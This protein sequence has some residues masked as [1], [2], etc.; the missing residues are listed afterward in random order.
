MEL[1]LLI[2]ALAAIIAFVYFFFY[3]VKQIIVKAVPAAIVSMLLN[4]VALIFAFII[5]GEE[6]I[7]TSN[8]VTIS[9]L[10]VL[11][12]LVVRGHRT[13]L[14]GDTN[15]VTFSEIWDL[16]FAGVTGYLPIGFIY[17]AIGL[18]GEMREIFYIGPAI[19][20]ILILKQCYID[21]IKNK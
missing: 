5:N 10:N 1:V 3:F 11:T 20:Y 14:D 12:I 16:L 2:L 13:I 17:V 4:T 7:S 21:F 15:K 8:I 6:S 19:I 9:I 18:F